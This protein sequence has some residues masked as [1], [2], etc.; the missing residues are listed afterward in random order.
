MLLKVGEQLSKAVVIEKK[1]ANKEDLKLTDLLRYYV[2]DGEAAKD[3]MYRRIKVT[4]IAT[5]SCAH[6]GR[7]S[8]LWIPLTRSSNKQ[9]QRE[10]RFLRPKR[11]IHKV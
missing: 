4:C 5:L 3:L 7:R 6:R 11:F 2:A 1:L 9:K 10:R 8:R